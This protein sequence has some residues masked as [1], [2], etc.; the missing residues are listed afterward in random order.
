MVVTDIALQRLYHQRLFGSPLETPADVV[1][2]LGAIQAQDYHGTKWSIGLRMRNATDKLVE[3][4][5][6]EGT[7]LRTHVMRPTWH[8]VTPAD[9]RWLLELTASRV[10]AA[11]AYMHRQVKLD[12]RLFLRSN[13]VI[14]EALQDVQDLTRAELGSALGKAGITAEGVQ[15]GYIIQRAE[16]DAIVCRAPG[17][18]NSSPMPY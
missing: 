10:N 1:K 15:L 16:L 6:N 11:N 12:D 2:R 4:A 18:G 3:S 7:I 13:A 9:I 8:F 14:A 17:E 5:F